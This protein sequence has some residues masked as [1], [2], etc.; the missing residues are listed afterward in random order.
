MPSVSV[1]ERMLIRDP[2]KGNNGTEPETKPVKPCDTRG[3]I[4]PWTCSMR[5]GGA[6]LFFGTCGSLF[7]D[8]FDKC[9]DYDLCV[10]VPNPHRAPSERP[11]SRCT[12]A[13]AMGR[14]C[15][16]RLLAHFEAPNKVW[17]DAV[18]RWMNLYLNSC[19][20]LWTINSLASQSTDEAIRTHV[21][22]SDAVIYPPPNRSNAGL[23]HTCK[24][25]NESA[26]EA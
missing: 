6:A 10:R 4:V 24:R 8:S 20:V 17:T 21:C 15:A 18:D 26:V 13:Y 11:L 9:F 19:T 25:V 2:R 7:P 3:R 22:T 14:D 23:S 12:H 1:G 16:S 5:M